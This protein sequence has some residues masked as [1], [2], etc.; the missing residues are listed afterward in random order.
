MKKIISLSC[1]MMIFI[2]PISSS[3]ASMCSKLFTSKAHKFDELFFEKSYFPVDVQKHMSSQNS[4]IE[5]VE[6]QGSTAFVKVSEVDSSNNGM[7]LESS[8]TVRVS[9]DALI[10]SLDQ[11]ITEYADGFH[12]PHYESDNN[13]A[14]RLLIFALKI[15]SGLA[16]DKIKEAIKANHGIATVIHLK[17]GEGYVTLDRK[18]GEVNF[19]QN[20]HDSNPIDNV[21]YKDIA[22]ILPRRIESPD[23]MMSNIPFKYGSKKY[24]TK[25]QFADGSILASASGEYSTKKIILKNVKAGVLALANKNLK[26]N[27]KVNISSDFQNR[28]V[29]AK[30]LEISGIYA[31]VRYDYTTFDM[32]RPRPSQ[33][34]SDMNWIPLSQ[35]TKAR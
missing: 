16:T 12:K 2:L 26:V 33:D 25:A 24:L 28:A 34:T 6:I 14:K 10:K 7:S 18:T 23:E 31:L 3:A 15:K 30:I 9:I 32:L 4:V 29:N 22:I 35:L 8:I 17:Y 5:S 27:D 11:K 21:S 19:S 1:L 20:S 13:N